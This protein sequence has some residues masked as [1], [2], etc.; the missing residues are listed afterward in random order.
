MFSSP[1]MFGVG[2][3]V[4]AERSQK[5]IVSVLNPHQAPHCVTMK[6]TGMA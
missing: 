6:D 1:Q 2:V 4:K 3:G 5:K